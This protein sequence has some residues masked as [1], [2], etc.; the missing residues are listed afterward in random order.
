MHALKVP[1]TRA[2]RQLQPHL[3]EL[4]ARVRFWCIAPEER[5][6]SGYEARSLERTLRQIALTARAVGWNGYASICLRVLE[7]LEPA[8]RSGAVPRSSLEHLWCWTDA[9]IQYLENP[10]EF[11]R[12]LDLTDLLAAS[13]GEGGCSEI[14]R[15]VLLS[16]LLCEVE[17]PQ[18]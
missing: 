16:E 9:S 18:L 12:A 10:A 5:L 13:H 6:P 11:A 2:V 8:F 4:R 14:E 15:H 1:T 3:R 17:S 7:R